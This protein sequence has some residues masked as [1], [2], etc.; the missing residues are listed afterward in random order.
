M[1]TL[2]DSN[3]LHI[4]NKYHPQYNRYTSTFFVIYSYSKLDT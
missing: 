1:K 3:E 4:R 2:M